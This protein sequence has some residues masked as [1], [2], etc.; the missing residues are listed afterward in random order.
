MRKSLF[1]S[2]II[3]FS[4]ISAFAGTITV[5]E[6]STTITTLGS[7]SSCAGSASSYKGITV[8]GTG[9]IS[10][11][12]FTP[13]SSDFEIS[14]TQD[15]SNNIGTS[16]AGITISYT[17]NIGVLGEYLYVRMTSAAS[18]SPSGSIVITSSGSTTVNLAV[19]GTVNASPTPSVT[20]T[21]VN[22]IYSNASS[23][24]LPFTINAGSPDKYILSS[25]SGTGANPMMGF[26]GIYIPTSLST[27]PLTVNT[28][29]AQ[30]A[31]GNT[32]G[33]NIQ[34]SNS[35]TGCSSVAQFF[36]VRAIAA[37]IAS[38]SAAATLNA[39]NTCAGTASA[40]QS[41]TL[42]GSNL[43]STLSVLPPSGYEVSASSSFATS[44]NR[45]A[46][47]L[48][49]NTT[50]GSLNSTVYVRLASGS[51]AGTYTR[52]FNFLNGAMPIG[53]SIPLIFNGTVTAAP[54]ITTGTITSPSATAISFDIPYTATTGSP[55][56][57]SITT[58]T[59]AMS[60]FNAV[61]NTSLNSSPITVTIPAGQGG[62]YDFNLSVKN[63]TSGCV[64]SNNALTVTVAGSAQA[65][66]PTITT[67]ATTIAAMN[68]CLGSTS[69]ASN[70][71]VSGSNL[72][73]D[74]IITPPVGF[75]VSTDLFSNGGTPGTNTSPLTITASTLSS[76]S[77]TVGV[78]MVSSATGTPSGNI[79]LAS[80]GATTK[81][82]AVSGTVN[83]LPTITIGTVTN[84]TTTASSFILPVTAT[85]GN[86]NLY[87][88]MTGA[89]R[90]S[91]FL[92]SFG[93]YNGN[94][95]TINCP[96]TMTAGTY[97]FNISVSNAAQCNIATPV[98]FTLT[99]LP[100]GTPIVPVIAYSNSSN[101]YTLGTTIANLTPTVS[102]T[103]DTWTISPVLSAGLSFNTTTGGISGTPTEIKAET[104]YT[105]TAT[106]TS[107]SG[108]A[109]FTIN[110]QSA[111][112][113]PVLSTTSIA[114]VGQS[115]INIVP[116]TVTGN[117]APV[118]S[119]TPALPAGVVLNT[120]T[121]AITG[122]P[123]TYINTTNYTLTATNTL[124]SSTATFNLSILP[125]L[126]AITGANVICGNR[127]T[128]LANATG[129]GVWSSSNASVI[130]INAN[131]QLT[132]L[133]TADGQAV[134]TYKLTINE[135]SN[136]VTY[137]VNYVA[138]P[139][140]PIKMQSI[141]A[142]A[143]QLTP[144][145][146][147]TFG[148]SYNWVVKSSSNFGSTAFLSNTSISNPNLVIN[149]ETTFHIEIKASNGCITVDTLQAKIFNEASAYLPTA[150]S[151]NGDGVNDEFKI[152]PVG[153]VALRYFRIMNQFGQTV[154]ETS[155]LSQGWDGRSGG[156]A[157]PIA[158]YIW[159][160]E[161]LDIN[162]NVLKQSGSVTLIR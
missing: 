139:V 83:D 150:F 127:M 27:S 137:N 5:K 149:A 42:T 49:L 95:I 158:T 30:V 119:V 89:R 100:A 96:S 128:Q 8:V 93:S 68:S 86:V 157:Q 79:S 113:T 19:S 18:G 43:S 47:Y 159:A 62:T 162:G 15:F 134:I 41:V 17:G 35:T 70:F 130:A 142:V 121:G 109:S 60:G 11:V 31:S 91:Q 116:S 10:N 37:P 112:S 147:R 117:P 102:N 145:Q 161:T 3:L 154:F 151:P 72:T 131:G 98:A 77:V 34:F 107:G 138:S 92:P 106:N 73:A 54:T 132:G 140:A 40:G 51:A 124:G 75:E 146:A 118:F 71:T 156:V 69:M 101:V 29:G 53:P 126:S 125:K 6:N 160:A 80:T 39:F 1:L 76:R 22:D 122:T 59:R 94:A 46:P 26:Q 63:T 55:N 153:I 38:M 66:T 61:S 24:S 141:D 7:F 108:T 81:T 136:A 9:L 152:V 32:Y 114:M 50:S 4:A 67:S 23:F 120:V 21:A 133:G 48:T 78:R 74:V 85:T 87:G 64:S 58:G 110:I 13:S 111:P 143:N 104:V 144:L 20:L 103:V 65:P 84:I 135:V 25:T 129:G 45:V 28:L 115:A 36:T 99:V 90:M 12:V 97:D 57:Y 33:F 44:Y 52:T 14:T 148:T 56:Q 88:I 16:T 2:L 155:N 105:V 82:I 123:T